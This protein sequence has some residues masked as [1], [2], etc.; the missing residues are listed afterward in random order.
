MINSKYIYIVPNIIVKQI[1]LSSCLHRASA[2][3]H[4]LLTNYDAHTDSNPLFDQAYV[5]HD[6]QHTDSLLL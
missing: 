2:E 5:P 1:I 4:Y 3:F 6:L